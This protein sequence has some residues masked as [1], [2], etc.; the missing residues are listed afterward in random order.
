M[1]EASRSH[2][3]FLTLPSVY[4][5]FPP[6]PRRLGCPPRGAERPPEG[7]PCPRAYLCGTSGAARG[8]VARAGREAQ[9]ARG[10][11]PAGPR[12]P[13]NAMAPERSAPP[14]PS[15]PGSSRQRRRAA[16]QHPQA[17]GRSRKEAA[18][19]TGKFGAPAPGAAAYGAGVRGAAG[20][21]PLAPAVAAAR[22]GAHPGPSP[23]AARV[24]AGEARQHP[25]PPAHRAEPAEP[26]A[27]R[28]T[29]SA[30]GAGGSGAPR[31]PGPRRRAA[32]LP[33]SPQSPPSRRARPGVGER[34][35][36]GASLQ[37]RDPRRLGGEGRGGARGARVGEAPVGPRSSTGALLGGSSGLGGG[38]EEWGSQRLPPPPGPLSEDKRPG[39]ALPQVRRTRAPLSPPPPVRL[40]SGRG[41]AGAEVSGPL[42]RGAPGACV[43]AHPGSPNAR[44]RVLR[45]LHKDPQ[46]E[47]RSGPEDTWTWRRP[48]FKRI[49]RAHPTCLRC[50]AIY[51]L[52][53]KTQ[54]HLQMVKPISLLHLSIYIAF[55]G[56]DGI[57]CQDQQ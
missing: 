36:R 30:R 29:E 28:C 48:A 23:A 31:A 25:L 42:P 52:A 13:P 39:P 8:R 26:G 45:F 50:A 5:L 11:L 41:K 47:G 16:S 37:A 18:T 2:R 54:V 53:F 38:Q 33:P 1:P 9:R 20:F 15:G 56:F 35:G 32:P 21:L 19:G 34:W 6:S 4:F 14:P 43:P 44:A 3:G 17:P 57:S 10:P 55:L 40:P 49:S 46:H 24:Q 22:L 27:A 12:R 51:K 7:R